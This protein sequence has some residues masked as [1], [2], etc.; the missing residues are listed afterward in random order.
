[1]NHPH[2]PLPKTRLAL[3]AAALMAGASLA[4][5]VL[6]KAS[7]GGEF[8]VNTFVTNSQASPAIALDTDGD[9]VLVWSS[10]AQPSGDSNIY[11]Q[12][13]NTA[14]VAQGAEF[15]VNTSALTTTQNNPAVAMDADGDFVVSWQSSGQDDPASAVGSG[16]YAQR[17]NAAGV[18]QG[19]EFRVNSVTTGS[20]QAP[21]IGM[22]ADGDFVVS[23]QSTGQDDPA[24]AGATGVYAQRYNAAGVAQGS[25][26]RVNTFT[27]GSQNNTAIALDA[28]G[29]FVVIWQSFG[30]D[31]PAQANFGGIYAQRYN[32]A[33]VAQGG[34][35]R[36]NTVT[37]NSQTLPAIALDADG[38]FVV[39]WQSIGQDGGGTGVYAQ[40]YNAAGVAQ[41]SE[42]RVNSFTTNAQSNT[43]IALDADGDF[44]VSWQSNG[45]DE[46]AQATLSGIYAQ[47]YNAAGVA[48]GSEFQVNT[49]VTRT[50]SFP[51][52]A[53]DAD[54][55]FV[56]SWQSTGQDDPAGSTTAT[57]I[58]AQRYQ[59][60][61]LTPSLT[62]STSGAATNTTP[63]AGGPG[64][65]YRFN[66]QFCN[67]TALT[68]TGLSSKTLTL[69]NGNNLLNRTRDAL[70]AP[71]AAAIPAGGVGS[72]K[73][74]TAANG[75]ADLALTNG[76]CVTVPYQIGLTNRNQFNFTIRIRGDN[77]Q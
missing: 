58:Y 25:E 21:A 17:Y 73:D 33:G 75:Y 23:W 18:A 76:E 39:S 35:F 55:D 2:L 28:D 32:A 5:P 48:Q 62:V 72:E 14:G 37:T 11:A 47:R 56:V 57:G 29:D 42:F 16:V 71:G 70:A 59:A 6:A 31:E 69:T 40:R 50:Q 44:V 61:T 26:F 7:A 8:L 30:Q 38:D 15:L 3:A 24:A 64:G 43:T 4:T 13:Y 19:G 34:E 54:G 77:G 63:V 22:D 1:M 36:V 68:M 74:L 67:N 66:A 46:P 52:I 49:F 9:F 45:Q 10:A 65:T 41:G 51:A 12:R 20:Q 60:D 53:L 27:T